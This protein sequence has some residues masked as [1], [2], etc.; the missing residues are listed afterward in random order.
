MHE[1]TYLVMHHQICNKK[2]VLMKKLSIQLK[3]EKRLLQV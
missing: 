3:Y 1:L 2:L